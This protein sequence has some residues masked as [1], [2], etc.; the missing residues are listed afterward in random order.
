[1]KWW[2]RRR[3][4]FEGPPHALYRRTGARYFG[5]CALGIVLNGVLVSGFGVIVLLFYVDLSLGEAALFTACLALGYAVEGALAAR[6]FLRAAEPARAWL[7]DERADEDAAAAWLAAARLPLMLVRRASLY[8]IGAVGAAAASV[9]VAGLL[10]L[11]THRAA[12]LFPLSYLLY[13]S[14]GVLR[15]VGLELSM[16]P[17]LSHIGEKLPELSVP[18]V[19]RVTLHQRLLATV[20]MVTWGTALIVGGLV[21]PNTRDLDTV[22]LAGVV[23]FGVTAAV[24]IWLSLVLADASTRWSP[25]WVSASSFA[26]P[27]APSSTPP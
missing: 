18:R 4:L 12:L 15:Y 24:S 9:L 22:G 1:M 14:C 11:P 19:A 6:Y 23:A 3:G 13:I 8:A 7:A 10:D 16:R 17:V 20:P 21:T 25:G 26:R 2:A 27:S 5:A